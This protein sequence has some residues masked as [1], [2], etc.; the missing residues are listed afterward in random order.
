MAVASS[1][2]SPMAAMISR[3]SAV[4]TR[5]E[6]LDAGKPPRADARPARDVDRDDV[7]GRAHRVHQALVDLGHDEPPEV[8]RLHGLV[9][10]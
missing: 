8:A 6:E 9:G 2:A 5:V 3:R 7:A 1:V 4:D 10:A